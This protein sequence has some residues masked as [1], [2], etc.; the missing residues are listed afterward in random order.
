MLNYCLSQSIFPLLDLPK[1]KDEALDKD[2]NSTSS[3]IVFYT[4][5]S[6]IMNI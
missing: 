4:F 3:K 5:F 6:W 1:T 2:L